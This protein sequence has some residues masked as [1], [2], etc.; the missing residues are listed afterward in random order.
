L[1]ETTETVQRGAI[2]EEAKSGVEL[3]LSELRK[4]LPYILSYD[5]TLTMLRCLVFVDLTTGDED[6]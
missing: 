3:W 1:S 5:V 6:L 4:S 2:V